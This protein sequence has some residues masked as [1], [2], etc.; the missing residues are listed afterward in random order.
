M[1]ND[2]T[3]GGLAVLMA[4]T[5]VIFGWGLAAPFAYEPVGP[6]AFPMI[7]AILIGACGIILLVKGG[8]AVEPNAA[9]VNRGIL[10]IAAAL[11]AYAL[12]FQ[13]LGFVVSTALMSAVVARIFGA[14]WA[15]SVS[16]GVV[17]SVGSFLLFD[18]G[19]DVVLPTGILGD[20]L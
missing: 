2:R 15:Q 19:L 20:L 13:S 8:G 4:L 6:R 5:L 10:G 1:S 7:T 17:L 11:L 18:H 14:T 9:G 16:T 3:L 12:V